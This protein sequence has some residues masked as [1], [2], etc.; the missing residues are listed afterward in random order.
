MIATSVAGLL[1]S[2]IRTIAL[3][4]LPQISTASPNTRSILD[5]GD[6]NYTGSM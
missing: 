3:T 4:C 5:S 6:G 1:E 2:W